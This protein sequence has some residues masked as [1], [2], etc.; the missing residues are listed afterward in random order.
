MA[1]KNSG[2]GSEKVVKSA[3]QIKAE[4]IAAR[5]VT[6]EKYNRMSDVNKWAYKQLSNAVTA[7]DAAKDSL[8]EGKTVNADLVKACATIQA[9]VAQS[10]LG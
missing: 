7:L 6:S 2:S 10:M 5:A 1:Q 9:A 3:E 4:R 8:L